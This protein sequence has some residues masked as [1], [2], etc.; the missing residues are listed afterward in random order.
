VRLVLA[1]GPGGSVDVVARLLGAK[2]GE[3]LGQ[4]L[5]IEN[6][7]GADAD[8][9]GE[10]VARAAPDGYTL[11]L[12]S[13]ALAVN[14][15]LRPKRSYKIED[16][17]PVTLHAETQAVLVVPTTSEA[18]SV[19][20]VVAMAKAQPGKLDYGSTGNGTSGHLAMELFHITAGIDIVHVP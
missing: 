15:S 7:P 12:T 14:A 5:I 3:S 11:L 17:A 19:E 4:A 8:L 18:K 9:A 10:T 2:A 6:K 20:N 1:F 13:Q 16:L